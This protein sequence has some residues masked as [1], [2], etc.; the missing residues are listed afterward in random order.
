MALP[1]PEG[2]VPVQ[3]P[4]GKAAF[5]EHSV[6]NTGIVKPLPVAF[7]VADRA[8]EFHFGYLDVAGQRTIR[9]LRHGDV[10]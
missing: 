3:L 2:A 7:M 8:P 5:P 1:K 10:H 6:Y 4:D 9:M